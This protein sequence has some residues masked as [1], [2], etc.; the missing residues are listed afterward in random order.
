MKPTPLYKPFIK[1]PHTPSELIHTEAILS[2]G[3]LY[4]NGEKGRKKQNFFMYVELTF[5][6]WSL[7]LSRC[8]RYHRLFSIVYS[9]FYKGYATGEN[10]S[11]LGGHG[12]FEGPMQV[13]IELLEKNHRHK[14]FTYNLS[15]TWAPWGL[16]I[17]YSEEWIIKINKNKS[18]I[19][20]MNSKI[21]F[22]CMVNLGSLLVLLIS[23]P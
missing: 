4:F 3:Y 1:P 12:Y 5:W 9:L 21:L 17:M 10:I 23:L 15:D 2:P 22:S 8:E 7:S 11:I 16:F 6:S 14:N 13:W 19:Y 18:S 20:Y